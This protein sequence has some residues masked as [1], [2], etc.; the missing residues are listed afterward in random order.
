MKVE[1]L[2]LLLVVAGHTRNQWEQAWKPLH[3]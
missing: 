2:A 1:P 3:K